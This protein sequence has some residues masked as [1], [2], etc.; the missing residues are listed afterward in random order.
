MEITMTITIT[1][2]IKAYLRVL[3]DV[4][5]FQVYDLGLGRPKY[6]ITGLEFYKLPNSSQY[7]IIVTASDCIFTFQDTLRTDDK[8]LQPIFN[9]YI[10]GTQSHGF[11]MSKTDLNYSVLRFYAAP[12]E[13]FPS[14]WG[15]L[16]GTGL[17]HGQVM[18]SLNFNLLILF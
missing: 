15:W 9:N 13:K 4:F 10:N 1:D 12:N 6:P 17:R 5:L 2:N 8:S 3:K 18:S 11:E 16:S 14:T 7:I